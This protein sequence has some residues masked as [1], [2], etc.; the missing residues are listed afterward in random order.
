LQLARGNVVGTVLAPDGTTPIAGAIVYAN[1]V[2]ATNEDRAVVTCTVSDGTYGFTLDPSYQWNIR[3]FPANSSTG[4]QY[5]NKTNNS[6]ISPQN[7]VTTIFNIT[8]D[9]KTP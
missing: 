9:L 2:G 3:V 5:A 4:P 7:N 1:I 6:P 8:L